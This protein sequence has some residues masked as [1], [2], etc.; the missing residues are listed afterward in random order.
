MAK[1]SIQEMFGERIRILRHERGLSQEELAYRVGI[2]RT[3]I[4]GI[5][6]GERNPA[7]KNIAAIA[8]ALGLTV[9]ELFDFE[10]LG[11]KHR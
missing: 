3:Y 9:S 5:E 6:R 4:G 7:L 8:Q 11:K 10:D 2:H 1:K